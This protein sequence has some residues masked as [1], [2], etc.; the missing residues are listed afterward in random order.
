MQNIIDAIKTLEEPTLARITTNTVVKL[1]KR[2]VATK[3]IANPYDEIRKVQVRIVELNPKYEKA[4]NAQ[5]EAEG[6]TA[7]FES[8][9][10]KWGTN[11]GNGIVDKNG[12]L[13]VSVILKDTESTSY[14]YQDAPID[15]AEFVAYEP[16]SKPSTNQGIEDVVMFMTFAAE[17]ITAWELI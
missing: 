4:V 13:Y 15:K 11:L 12:K 6:K 14:L 10:R 16:V 3:T 1:N 17:N 8:Q 7:D 9:E 2:D 5:R